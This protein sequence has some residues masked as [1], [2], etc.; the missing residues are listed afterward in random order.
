VLPGEGYLS[1][2]MSRKFVELV[3]NRETTKRL[4]AEHFIL[5]YVKVFTS[6]IENLTD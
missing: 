1:F 4:T 6:N 2:Y 3:L 5:C